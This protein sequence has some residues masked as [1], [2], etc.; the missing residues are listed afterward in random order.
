TLTAFAFDTGVAQTVWRESTSTYTTD[1][2]SVAYAQGRLMAV[3]NDTGAAHLDQGRLGVLAD[4][5]VLAA[6][7]DTG[8]V[9][10]AVWSSHATRALSE[11]AFD[12]GVAHTVWSSS[13]SSFADTGSFAY[14]QGRIQK[15]L[16]D[17]GAA[18][19]DQGRFGVLSDSGVAAAVLS[20][21]GATIW[22][23]GDTGSR[24][25]NTRML[26]N[27]TG[28]A[29]HLQQSYDPSGGDANVAAIKAKTDR[30]SFDTGSKVQAD[31][32]KVNN[33]PVTGTGTSGDEWGP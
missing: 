6:V 30:L 16:G 15:V 12:T 1:T 5:G 3:R 26:A 7:L 32:R 28:A 11:F 14:A 2:G 18:H 27:D 23:Y 24:S 25:V 17:T 20:D 19:L 8:K 4:S 9:A 21:I 22:T 10:S 29:K 31:I 13:Q 33:A